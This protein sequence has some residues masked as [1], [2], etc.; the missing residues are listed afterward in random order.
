MSDIVCDTEFVRELGANLESTVVPIL[1]STN[2]ILPELSAVDRGL[3]T[4]VTLPM[5]VA[6]SMATATVTESMAG[7]A[8]C[9]RQLHQVIDECAEHW[10]EVDQAVDTA[11]GGG[12]AQ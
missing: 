10:D 5:A 9:F 6:Y 1:E 12:A 7:A 11:F 2:D 4:A 8:E 3:Y